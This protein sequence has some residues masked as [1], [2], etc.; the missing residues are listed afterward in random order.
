MMHLCWERVLYLVWSA[1]ECPRRIGGLM[2]PIE[3]DIKTEG[4]MGSIGDDNVCDLST[5][6]KFKQSI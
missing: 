6:S 2:L 4:L 5:F 3:G 1:S